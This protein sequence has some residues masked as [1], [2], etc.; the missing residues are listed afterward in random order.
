MSEE[1]Q[2]E[3]NKG[4]SQKFTVQKYDVYLQLGLL[5]D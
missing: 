1:R 3:V 2:A 5:K 4:V